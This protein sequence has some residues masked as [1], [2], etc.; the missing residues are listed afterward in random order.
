MTNSKTIINGREIYKAALLSYDRVYRYS[1]L[2]RWDISK[3]NAVFIGLNPSTANETEDDPTIRR[4]VR[5]AADWG[6]GGLCMINLFAFRATD[7]AD[8]QTAAEPVGPLNDEH[9]KAL[10]GRSGI[11]IAAWGMGGGFQNRG[12]IVRRMLPGL[13]ILRLTKGG[14]PAHPLYLPKTLKPILWEY[15]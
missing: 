7:P 1:L 11:V 12:S 6:Y 9:I 15:S 5:F 14:Y 4:C 2:R 3:D 10:T 8:M 13:H